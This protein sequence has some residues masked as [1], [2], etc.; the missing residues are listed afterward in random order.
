MAGWQAV[1]HLTGWVWVLD[2]QDDEQCEHTVAVSECVF[3]AKSD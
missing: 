3:T 1:Y 2:A